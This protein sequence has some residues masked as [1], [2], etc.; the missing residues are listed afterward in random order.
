MR[1][2]TLTS[3]IDVCWRNSSPK[4]TQTLEHDRDSL[5]YAV[6]PDR[7]SLWWEALALA[8]CFGLPLLQITVENLDV[9]V[10]YRNS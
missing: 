6:A 7:L 5:R 8:S 10:S 4:V 2:V 9:A 1:A 3:D